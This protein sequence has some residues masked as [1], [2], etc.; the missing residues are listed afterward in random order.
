MKTVS[1]ISFGFSAVNAGQRNVA[2]E[3]QV[4][5]V[6]T[7]G[8]FRMT[9][10]VSRALGLAS[11][12]YVAFLHNI[13]DI[14]AAIDTK[15]E[16]YVAFCEANGLEVGSPESVIAIHKEFDMWAITKGFI[17]YD[18]KGNAKTTTERLTKHDKL[19][20]VSQHFE[21]MLS[22]ALENAEQEI[23]DALSRD[24]VTKEEQMD[25]LSSFVK[26]REL[27]KYKGSK[28]ANPAGLTGIGTSLTFTD[29]NVW[30][31]LKADMGEEATKMNRVFSVNLDEIQD[32]QVDNGYEVITVKAYIL[33]DFVDKAPARIGEK[34]ADDTEFV[35][36]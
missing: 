26:P 33:K 13:D 9:P 5:A 35:E 20:F 7:E 11:G 17:V 14:N 32:I 25:I 30:K 29:A 23:K 12:D 15:A 24:G 2:V 8:N 27:P 18:S 36:E 1:G 31:Q 21:E 3:P 28:T 4:I 16:P 34:E 10:P 22:S 6:S 19:R